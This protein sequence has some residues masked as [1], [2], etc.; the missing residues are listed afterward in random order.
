MLAQSWRVP[1]VQ[2]KNIQFILHVHTNRIMIEMHSA[3]NIEKAGALHN[4]ENNSI[5]FLFLRV[6]KDLLRY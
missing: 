1:V 6:L 2:V 5:N 4:T 3:Y